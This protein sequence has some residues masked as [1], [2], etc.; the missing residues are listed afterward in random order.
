[1]RPRAWG[2]ATLAGLVG[3]A[4]TVPNVLPPLMESIVLGS[5]LGLIFAGPIGLLATAKSRPVEVVLPPDVRLKELVQVRKKENNDRIVERERILNNF[6]SLLSRVEEM[7]D[8]EVNRKV[9]E[10]FERFVVKLTKHY[11]AWDSEG[12]LRTYVLMQKIS[13]SLNLHNADA[14]LDMAYR[15]LMARGHEA[16]EMSHITLNGKVE[17]MYRDPESEGAHR[18]AG[19][20]L[21]MNRGNDEYATGMVAD[22]IHL[23]SDTRFA[24][25]KGDFAAVSMLGPKEKDSIVELLEKEIGKTTRARNEKAAARARDILSTVLTAD[26]RPHL[27][28]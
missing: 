25:A 14:Y 13:D 21:L 26:P 23:W 24:R 22:A 20:L 11:P 7:D 5:S 19:T 15:T 17:Q 8:P 3:L 16:T 6:D 27:L 18:L 10:D 9:T 28:H 1:M 4:V 2:L 12:R